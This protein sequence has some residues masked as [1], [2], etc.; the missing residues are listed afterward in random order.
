MKTWSHLDII[1]K[2]G[3]YEIRPEMTN[4]QEKWR[5]IHWINIYTCKRIKVIAIFGINIYTCKQIKVIAIFGAAY[6]FWIKMYKILN[7]HHF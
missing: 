7:H 1:F 4:Y 3:R 2:K 6:E 5:I